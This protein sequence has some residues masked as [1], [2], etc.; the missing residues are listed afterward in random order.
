MANEMICHMIPQG[1]ANTQFW[2]PELTHSS[3]NF[4]KL[5]F[6]YILHPHCSYHLF[7]SMEGEAFLFLL[8]VVKASPCSL[9]LLLHDDNHNT[10]KIG[11]YVWIQ[12]ILIKLLENYVHII[13]NCLQLAM[14]M[15]QIS[16][17]IWLPGF[18][19]VLSNFQHTI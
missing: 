14:G 13:M 4:A 18:P 3:H 16:G 17:C 10:H 12:I 9:S 19:G 5:R 15:C 11:I 2:V 7:L 1:H 6:V 8:S